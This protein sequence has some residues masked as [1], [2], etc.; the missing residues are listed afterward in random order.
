MV[1]SIKYMYFV[2]PPFAATHAL[3]R[4]GMESYEGSITFS[5]DV[6]SLL[7]C[8]SPEVFAGSR[9]AM[10]YLFLQNL[11]HIL[12]N[13]QIQ[14]LC[15][16]WRQHLNI[17]FRQKN[18]SMR[19]YAPELH[20]VG[21]HILH[22]KCVEG[23]CWTLSSIQEN[24]HSGRISQWLENHLLWQRPKPWCRTEISPMPGHILPSICCQ[25]YSEHKNGGSD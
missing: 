1:P 9:I 12:D 2:W 10:K 7:C 13:W 21:K 20:P 14:T 19:I 16:S 23:R 24:Q 5:W 6:V 17:L 15:W 3:N 11:S 22:D 4:L 18:G 25:Y 8:H